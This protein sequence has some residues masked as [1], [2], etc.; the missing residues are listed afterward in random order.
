MK[1]YLYKYRAIR[2]EKS[3]EDDLTLK[4]LFE[5]K[6]VFSSRKLFNDLFDSKIAFTGIKESDI[7]RVLDLGFN[8]KAKLPADRVNEIETMFSNGLNKMIDS[9]VFYSLSANPTS[10]L[11][12]AHYSDSHRGFCIEFKK[13]MMHGASPI[14]YSHKIAELGLM[15]CMDTQKHG[16]KIGIAVQKALQVKLKEWSY[17]KEYRVF[18]NNELRNKHLLSDGLKAVIPYEPDWVE[19]LIFGCRMPETIQEH[20]MA[21]YPTKIKFK[22]AV[23]RKSHIEI[24]DLKGS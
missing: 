4:A 8:L 17:E 9:Y 21:K 18:P 10:N 7:Q 24:V 12:W 14:T 22:K 2:D 20:I 16:E 11:M 5:H 15:Y 23:E 19:S 1:K 3:L 13:E 6:A